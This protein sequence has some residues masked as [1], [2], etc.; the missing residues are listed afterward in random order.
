M[1]R[2]QSHNRPGHTGSDGNR[3]LRRIIITAGL[4][5]IGLVLVLVAIYAGVFLVLAPMMQ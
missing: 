4:V 5:L 2:M 1:K 3:G